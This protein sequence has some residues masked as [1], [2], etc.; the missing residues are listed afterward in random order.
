[1]QKRTAINKRRLS[2]LY[3]EKVRPQARAFLVWDT[4]QK[5]LALK[6][7]PSGHRAW[8]LIYRHQGRPRWFNI[9]D[10][11]VIGVADA[12]LKAAEL[13]LAV[14][15]DGKDPAAEKRS[16][17]QSTSFGTLASRY[18][19]EYARRKNKS[20]KQADTLIRRY[21][22]PMWADLDASAI[23][24]TDVRAMLGKIS[25]P[26]LANQVLASASAIFTWATRQELLVNN[27]CRGV[28]R[29]GTVSRERVLSDAEVPLFLR[30]F[31][32]AD[33]PGAALKILLLT[34]QRPGEVAHMRR[35]H[36]SDG[37][38]TL[39]G[40]PEPATE[41]PGT[42]NAQTHRVWLPTKVREIIAEL[43][44]EGAGFVFGSVLPL[45]AAMRD[46]C[47]HLQV[48]RVT[49]HDLRRTHGSAVTGLGFGRAAMDRIMNHREGGIASVYDRHQYAEE[50]KRV[51][52]AVAAR[53][54]A[55]VEGEATISNVVTL[56]AVTR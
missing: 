20:W 42:K 24:R 31:C 3:V 19:D 15:R 12:R 21:V 8:K 35:E 4:D 43:G 11:K 25:G 6:V 55:L 33:L 5:G 7:Q 2:A 44:G 45:D 30:A 32:S 49:P 27:P 47:K 14:V 29:H 37:W 36:I 51:M 40:L 54:L 52:E 18:V 10:A 50:N 46:I 39:P 38:W 26:V 48:S 23:T 9:G 13:M 17:R 53:L 22:L 28:E 56:N 1:M 16:G 41:W 34:G